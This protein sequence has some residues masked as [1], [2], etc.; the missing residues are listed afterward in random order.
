MILK[1]KEQNGVCYID[2]S[3]VRQ[4]RDL[5][6]SVMFYFSFKQDDFITY[7]KDDYLGF[8]NEKETMLDEIFKYNVAHDL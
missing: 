3:K 7:R 5:E 6:T 2:L 4:I 1:F 8:C